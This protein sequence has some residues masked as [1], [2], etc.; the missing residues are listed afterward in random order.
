METVIR[1]RTLG[2]GSHE[3]LGEEDPRQGRYEAQGG[4]AP[5][6]PGPVA[7]EDGQREAPCGLGPWA[8]VLSRGAT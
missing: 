5:L 1:G 8:Q 3:M 6:P 7:G 4:A 2:A